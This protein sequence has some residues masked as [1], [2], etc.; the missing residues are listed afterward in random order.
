MLMNLP[1]V[2]AV[3]PFTFEVI[4]KMLVVVEIL[5]LLLL[6]IVL[7]ETEPPTLEVSV[8]VFDVSELGTVIEATF[9]LPMFAS[10]ILVVELLVVE[11]FRVAK[12]AEFPKITVKYPDKPE[13]VLVTKSP[14]FP[15]AANKLVVV[16]LVIV[17]FVKV[18]SFVNE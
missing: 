2:V 10:P 9:K 18:G 4:S 1:P 11:A 12:L 3:T 17:A 16:A 5:K 13:I 14:I 6:I 15:T 7:V 8:F